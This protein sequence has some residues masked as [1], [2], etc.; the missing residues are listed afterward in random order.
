MHLREQF[1]REGSSR[2]NMRQAEKQVD[3]KKKRREKLRVSTA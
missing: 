3:E 2:L 1:V